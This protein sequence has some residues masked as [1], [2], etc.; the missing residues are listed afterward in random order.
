[1]THP[2][3]RATEVDKA[4]GAAVRKHRVAAGMSQHDLADKIGVTYQQAHKYERGINRI[5]VGRIYDIAQALNVPLADLF[6]DCGVSIVPAPD[7]ERQT[8]ELVRSFR[9]VTSPKMRAVLAA[10][11]RAAAEEAA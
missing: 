9:Q 8:L 2:K 6:A 7:T 4:V 5:S 1:M 3:S 11:V 10:M